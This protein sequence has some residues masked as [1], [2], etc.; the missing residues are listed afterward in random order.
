[1]IA[2]ETKANRIAAT[3]IRT[4][5]MSLLVG[6]ELL[7]VFALLLVAFG[8][9]EPR[10]LRMENIANILRSASI[11]GTLSLGLAFVMIPGDFD[12]SFAS[13]TGLIVIIGM[14]LLDK[15]INM[16]LVMLLMIGTGVLWQVVNALLIVRVTMHAFI[17]TLAMW[18]VSKGFIFWITKG[19][20]FYGSYPESWTFIGRHTVLKVLP[21]CTLIFGCCAAIAYVL[22]NHTKYGR[23]LYAIGS[24]SE[25]ARYVG[26]N[27][28]RCRTIAFLINGFCSGIAAIIL[29]SQITSGPATAG[30][31]Y[32]MTVITSA[33]LGAT[34]FRQGSVNIGGSIL[35]ILLM[36]MIEN[37]LVM[38]GVAFY[39]KFLLQ[40]V[41]IMAAVAYIALRLKNGESLGPTMM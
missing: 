4:R 22:S 18:T 1:L 9:A 34:V 30:E 38:V 8:M 40:G 32:Q 27:V 26:I 14:V 19:R 31:G 15:G 33:F 23:Y 3:T 36:T 21:V 2:K 35:A 20:T 11:A 29:A 16:W 17:A 28:A 41:I 10:F 6:R 12:L 7:V 5:M 24:N 37:G 39:Y 25:A 13:A